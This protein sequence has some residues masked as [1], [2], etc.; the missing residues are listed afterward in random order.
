MQLVSIPGR[1]EASRPPAG[2]QASLEASL[3]CDV[4]VLATPRNRFAQPQANRRA[5]QMIADRLGQTGYD[6]HV[7]GHHRNLLALPPAW[8]RRPLR[9]V[10]A[11]YDSVAGSPG[12]DDNA[13]GVAALL[14]LAEALS[15][16]GELP[17]GLGLV[18]FNAEE[19]GL[20]GSREVASLVLDEGPL[21]IRGVH[22]LESVGYRDAA[23]GSQRSPFELPL[24]GLL[25]EAGDFLGLLAD[26]RSRPLL[27]EVLTAA[28]RCPGAPPL[29][30][31]KTYLGLER[32]LP[33]LHR[34]DHS[35]F[36]AAR[37]PAVLWTDTAEFRTPH[38]H[39]W[40]DRPETLDYAFLAAVVHLLVEVA[41]QG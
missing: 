19:D 27:T 6:V 39:R 31:L 22:V 1:T 36:W 40:S 4:E 13:S 20:L 41:S 2:P 26:G 8:D 3:R 34:S 30:A 37:K 24:P 17:P 14:A 18:A 16:R 38:Y 7:V 25:P 21:P 33:V 11:H 29:V 28:R 35:P 15:R 32:H 5:A 12:A 23:R 9:L 10:G